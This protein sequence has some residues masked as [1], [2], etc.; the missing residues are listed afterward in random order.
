MPH[1][2]LEL[3]KLTTKIGELGTYAAA[4]NRDLNERVE[5]AR[6][7]F[8]SLAASPEEIARVAESVSRR[9]RWA[10]AIPTDE[11]LLS[12][13]DPIPRPTRLN[14][15]AADGSQ[16]KPDR[17]NLA[18]YYVI[19]IGSI[20]FRYGVASAPDVFRQPEV[21]FEDDELYYEEEASLLTDEMIAARRDVRE[22]GELARLGAMES[23][24]APT[25]ALLDNDLLLY[26][27]LREQ[28]PR[29]SQEIIEQYL[30]QLDTLKASGTAVAGVVDR[31]RS[32][33]VVRLVHLAGKDE[34]EITPE[35]LREVNRVYKHVTDATLFDFLGPGQR[36][37]LFVLAS[38]ASIGEYAEA[39]HKIYFFFLN[40]GESGNLLRVQVPE[41]VALSEAK[42][43]L[44][45]TA[46]V[47]Q[48]KTNGYP[49]VLARAHEEALIKAADK[50][51][52]D[53]MVA[54]ALANNGVPFSV[55]LKQM[56]KNLLS[57]KRRYR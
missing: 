18:L 57:G 10:G 25:V 30:G 1:M 26:I 56:N 17:H 35:K 54:S 45:H 24:T 28:N 23:P 47:A 53:E 14:V 4:R 20:A 16:I 13:F 55:S 49:Y 11:P 41:W 50:F 33:N 46:I 27:T 43:D 2:A 44:V 22:I 29:F 34:P 6:T 39:G 42:L 7:V 36:S 21:F 37:A 51:A 38:P 15:A 40:A 9:F 31:P 48:C 5:R 32:A 52:V 19:N 12:A 3:N 8:K